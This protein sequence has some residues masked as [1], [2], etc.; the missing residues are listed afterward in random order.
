MVA[1]LH[2]RTPLATVSTAIIDIWRSDC[3]CPEDLGTVDPHRASSM[4]ISYHASHEQYPPSELLGYT[5]LAED[6]GFEGVLSS[7]HFFPW[8]EENGHSGFSWS[9]LGAALSATSFPFGIVCAPGDRY[10]PAVAA[11]AAATLCEMFPNRFWMALGSGEALN[12]HVTGATWPPKD[13]RR[14]RLREC[15]DVMRALFH[16][17][18]VDHQGL[19]KVSDARLYSLPQVA[20]PLFAAAVSEESARWAGGWA[21]GLITTGRPAT[22]LRKMIEAFRTGG[23]EGP[24]Y[25]QHP[26]AW[27]AT[28][29]DALRAAHEQWRF[30]AV[31]GESIWDLRTPSDFAAAT[32][33]VTPE[34]VAERIRVSSSM[35]QH[36]DW[37][38]E[39]VEEGVS[40][41]FCFSVAK[42]QPAFIEEFARVVIAQ[43][44]S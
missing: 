38:A 1:L 6:A 43:L 33:N 35:A 2:D 37:I 13:V 31:E 24:I 39:Y 40:Q 18:T 41:V 27:A 15:V 14:A 19:V 11:Q 17:E 25:V 12:E 42:N 34:M 5:R 36:R 10:H 21:D 4:K 7:D 26:L 29:A 20:P 30:S 16:G 9:W 23:G 8:L 28:E 3:T 32:R 44:R 22:E